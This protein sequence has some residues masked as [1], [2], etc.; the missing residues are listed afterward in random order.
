MLKSQADTD[1]EPFMK[2]RPNSLSYIVI[3]LIINTSQ[4]VEKMNE[5][6]G[7]IPCPPKTIVGGY[8]CTLSPRHFVPLGL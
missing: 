6:S 8:V 3:I 1:H 4:K 2:R 7:D 5:T